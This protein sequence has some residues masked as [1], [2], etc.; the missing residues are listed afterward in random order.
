MKTHGNTNALLVLLIILVVGAVAYLYWISQPVDMA[1]KASGTVESVQVVI[2][3]EVGGRVTEV[4][5]EEGQAVQADNLLF[6]LDGAVW[7]AQKNAASASLDT[8]LASLEAA[9]A[10]QGTA[11]AAKASAESAVEVARL[12]YESERV[13]A[14]L[15]DAL[16]RKS[17]WNEETPD[18]FDQPGWYFQKS[19]ELAA[20]QAEVDKTR[21][22]LDDE[23]E[24]LAAVLENASGS[25]L[26]AAETRLAEARAAYRVADDLLERAKNQNDD[27]LT[28]EAQRYYDAVEAELDEAQK[29]FDQLLA[30]QASEDVL[31]ARARVT[32]A[33][34]CYETALDRL[35]SLKTG[36]DSLRVALAAAGLAQAET[37]V[38]QAEQGIL[39]AEANIQQAEKA[40]A[41]AQAQLD[42]I[43][44]QMKRLEVRAPLAGVVMTR[45]LEPGEVVQPGTAV[46]TIG[47]LD[48]LSITVFLPE[49]RYGLVRLGDH[50]QV[51]V[52]SFPGEIFTAQVVH[53][54]DTAEYT[55][56]NVQTD[57]GRRTTVYA[58]RLEV[59]EALGKLRPGMPA[60]VL[61]DEG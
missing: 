17:A 23:H 9:R 3:P 53:I 21:Q 32:V 8:A 12:R 14:R 35:N 60:T 55:P 36:E 6:R 52:D 28:D 44:A 15:E 39:Q 4:L 31:E 41:Q 22:M 20:A 54:S 16:Q 27:S 5:V 59:G 1:L 29:S 19:E 57:E 45:D 30:T 47:E 2:A 13:A 25:D 34:E 40:V 38:Q 10:S 24:T 58:I 18:A 11:Q 51:T 7:Q 43:D 56:R 37:S 48:E 26:A 33:Q 46:I 49:D 42:L 50:A 61:F